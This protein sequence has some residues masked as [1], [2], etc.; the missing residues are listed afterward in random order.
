[1]WISTQDFRRGFLQVRGRIITRTK[2]YLESNGFNL[3]AEISELKFYD[4]SSPFQVTSNEN[5]EK[6]NGNTEAK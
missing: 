6:Q 2:T 5:K 1:M 3:P 4:A